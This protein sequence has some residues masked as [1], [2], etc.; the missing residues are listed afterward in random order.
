MREND[1]SI[2][3]DKDL[4]EDYRRGMERQD[5]LIATMQ[6][7]LAQKNAEIFRLRSLHAEIRQDTRKVTL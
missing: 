2:R 7:E 3:S 1:E 5:R 4:A 6:A